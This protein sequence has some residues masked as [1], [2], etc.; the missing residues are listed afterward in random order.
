M[1]GLLAIYRKELA[2]HFGSRRFIIL[3]LLVCLASLSATYTAGESV[4]SALAGNTVPGFVF[5][6]LFTASSG[7][8]PPF[9]TFI[10]FL[11]PLVGLAL[12]FDSING[13]QNRG[14]LSRLLSQP[15]YRD[16]VINGKFLAGL[17][18]VSA[19]L[20]SIVVVVSALGIRI[21]GVLPTFDESVRLLAFLIVCI[22]YVGFWMALST[23]F[24]LL[25]RQTSTSA[26]AGIATWIFCTFFVTMIASTA[27][28][29]IVSVDQ[30][31]DA[32]TVI[33]NAELAQMISRVS[34]NTLFDE[35][36]TAILMPNIPTLSPMVM[37][38]QTIG[39]LPNPLPLTQ[40]LLL[41][42]P[43]VVG[44]LALTSACFAAAYVK[45]MTQEIRSL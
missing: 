36:S 12:A 14:T 11:G 5:L 22:L 27:A 33:R 38:S 32:Q 1:P 9:I 31:M 40:S 43:Q 2:D 18:T 21:L 26:L 15:I 23:M 37:V 3:Y 24:S 45:F 29:A 25:L 34:P 6:Y 39:R 4:R 8:L 10:G 13:E 42:W 19:M 41:V 30:A 20:V 17:T 7:T 44:L 28:N 16:A 35:A